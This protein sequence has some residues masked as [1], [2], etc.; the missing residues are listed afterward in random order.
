MT[1]QTLEGTWEEVLTHASDLAGRRV[2][3][4]VLDSQ[5]Q[6]TIGASDEQA[7]QNNA[8]AVFMSS[9]ISEAPLLSDKAINRE[10]LYSSKLS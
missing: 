10:N 9:T 3:V 4:I 5:E 6:Q 1:K 7:E 2:R 8:F